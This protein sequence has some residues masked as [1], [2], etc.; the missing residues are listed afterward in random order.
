LLSFKS[1]LSSKDFHQVLI[2]QA[3]YKNWFL[4]LKSQYHVVV[5]RLKI[6]YLYHRFPK[7]LTLM[8]KLHIKR[9][10]VINSAAAE[11]YPLLADFHNWPKWSPWLIMDPEATVT[12][13]PDGKSYSWT[14][15]YVG[16]G[17]MKIEE[18]TENQ[19]VY[20]DLLFLT[21]YKSKAKTY[22]E[23]KPVSDQKTEVTWFMDTTLP[24]FLFFMKSK[25][26]TMIS[27]DYVR[28]LTL[29]KDL[30]EKGSTQC[31]LEF[32]GLEEKKPFDYVGINRE[33]S[34]QEINQ[35]MEKDYQILY[36]L[37]DLTNH[38]VQENPVAFYKKWD[39]KNHKAEFTSAVS[40]GKIDDL[41]P[42]VISGHVDQNTVYKI[43]LKGPYH[44]LPTAWS[45]V[46][47]RIRTDKL[48]P[49]SGVH[50]YE[51]Y[52]SDPSKTKPEDLITDI[53][54]PVKVRK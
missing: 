41:P 22:F 23:L 52:V 42:E 49:L 29:L 19:S 24:F 35:I 54:F 4:N 18:E 47:N 34:F 11:V 46:Q 53:C 26:E 10:I 39:L 32:I 33:S 44:H 17:E 25:M 37:A 13:Q 12:V 27:M 30:V 20:C 16:S 5:V 28:G 36:D 38:P 40:L 43:R 21:P 3:S 50:P 1:V 2:G 51:E 48:K 45:A 9:S 14:G 31:K 15:K 7:T 8:P 6:G